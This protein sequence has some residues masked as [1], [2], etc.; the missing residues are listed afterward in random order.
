MW[1]YHMDMG[2]GWWIVGSVTMV[3]FWGTVIWLTVTLAQTR[4]SNN[5]QAN[6]DS[7][8]DIADRRLAAGEID[9]DEHRR[10]VERLNQSNPPRM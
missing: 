6:Y 2:W 8:R 1:G 4:E 7:A 3:V 9:H 10:I 5:S